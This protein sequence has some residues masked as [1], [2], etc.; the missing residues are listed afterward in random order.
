MTLPAGTTPSA[1]MLGSAA[2]ETVLMIRGLDGA[3]NEVI[4]AP[5]LEDHVLIRLRVD[6]GSAGVSLPPSTLSAL[7]E[8]CEFISVYLPAI[9]CTPGQTKY[10]WVSNNG[11][12]QDWFGSIVVTESGPTWAQ[13]PR[14]R[15]SGWCG[16]M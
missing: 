16:L 4:D 12:T 9:S 1:L 15:A 6:G 5:P 7:T 11:S 8:D 2:G 13:G 10:D 3:S 14:P